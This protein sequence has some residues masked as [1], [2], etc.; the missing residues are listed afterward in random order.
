MRYVCFLKVWFTHTLIFSLIH[1]HTIGNIK[2]R[3]EVSQDIDKI[4]YTA[5]RGTARIKNVTADYSATKK[6]LLSS[7][8]EESRGNR[9]RCSGGKKGS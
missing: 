4:C 7:G 6:Y 2:V 9:N 3:S 5:L 1:T 8:D